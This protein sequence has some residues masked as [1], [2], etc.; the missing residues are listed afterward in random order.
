[1]DSF[2][3]PRKR[4]TRQR[5]LLLLNGPPALTEKEAAAITDI[6][7][8]ITASAIGVT[9]AVEALAPYD[10]M[11]LI[12]ALDLLQ[13]ARDAAVSAVQLPRT[14]QN[15]AT[16]TQDGNAAT[17]SAHDGNAAIGSAR[18]GNAATDGSSDGG[19]AVAS[20]H[21]EGKAVASAHGEGKAVASAH[22][23]G[24]AV[25]S[26]HGEA[27]PRT[28]SAR[29]D[30]VAAATGS[31]LMRRASADGNQVMR[32]Q[33]APELDKTD[34]MNAANAFFAKMGVKRFIEAV[35]P[36]LP[37]PPTTYSAVET[38]KDPNLSGEQ[39]TRRFLVVVRGER[40]R[41][42]LAVSPTGMPASLASLFEPVAPPAQYTNILIAVGRTNTA[43]ELRYA[44]RYD[45]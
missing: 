29:Q 40:M 27:A 6:N 1:M 45:Y 35:G 13:Q 23:E 5:V 15:L 19:K 32:S 16:A 26:A 12:Q 42:A 43:H 2:W 34:M 18:D 10:E 8:Y 38:N 41:S 24:K 20:A 28:S 37:P 14:L 44:L 33:A 31:A 25:A 9:S 21:G 36:A 17:G 4:P 7:R 11:R 3:T 30:N 39:L 22:G